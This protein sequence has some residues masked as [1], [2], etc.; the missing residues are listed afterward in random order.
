MEE[1]QT[2][3]AADE[4]IA[5]YGIG[6]E[7][8]D[9]CLDFVE[10][11]TDPELEKIIGDNTELDVDDI[12]KIYEHITKKKE[13]EKLIESIPKITVESIRLRGQARP[14]KTFDALSIARS[15]FPQNTYFGHKN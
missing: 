11:A 13:E 4:Y 7:D 5:K 6:K 12:K 9:A 8:F 10:K 2:E 15:L 3:S 1:V 14:K